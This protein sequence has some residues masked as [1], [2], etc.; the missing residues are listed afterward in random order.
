[1]ATKT[2]SQI[3]QARVDPKLKKEA[4]AILDKVGMNTTQAF[5]LFLRQV[6][7]HKGLPFEA[8]VPNKETIAAFKEDVSKLPSYTDIKKMHRDILAGKV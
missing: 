7:M 2:K 5:T 3:V 8:K 1:M 4:T 6:V